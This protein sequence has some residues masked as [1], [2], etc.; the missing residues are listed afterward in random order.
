MKDV[1]RA[2]SVVQS[3]W[4]IVLGS[5]CFWHKEKLMKN[6]MCTYIISYNMIVEDEGDTI[7][8]WDDD[9]SEAL[10]LAS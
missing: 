6:I 2:F 1:E 10:T 8:K 3:Q 4:A 7:T 5:S 9:E